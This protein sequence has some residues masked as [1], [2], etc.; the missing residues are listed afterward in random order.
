[1]NML[2][3]R[4]QLRGSFIRWALLFVPGLILLGM[5]CA[6]LSGSGPDDPWFAQLVKPAAYPAPAVFAVV[7]TI[8]YA[9]M[10]FALALVVSARGA[11]R[12]G[13][14]VIAFL[15]QLALNLAW[16]PLFFGAHQITGALMLIGFLDAAVVVTIV[17]FWRIRPAAALLLTPYLVWI[18]F[19]T[20]LNWELRLNNLAMDGREIP[21]PV[22]R[23]EF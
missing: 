22:T 10:G 16:S 8:L 13:A 15:V 5:L 2:A 20:F 12:R 4:G 3:S 7:W 11:A 1:M 19:A 18:V 21:A 9:L 17:L 23:I 6:Q 14:A